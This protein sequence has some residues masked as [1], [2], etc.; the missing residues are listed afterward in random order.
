MAQVGLFFGSNTGNTEAVAYQ[1]QEAFNAIAPESV[2]V[3]NI[4][5]S[6]PEDI[7]KYDYLIFG[8]PTWNVGQLQD[9]WEAFLPKF[10]EM[11]MNGK[12]LAIFGLGDQNGYGFNF[13]DAVGML[14]DEA[15][16]AGAEL[17]GMWSTKD[18]YEYEESRAEVEDY[19]LGLPLDH[20]A[21]EDMCP[22]RIKQWV[23]EVKDEFGI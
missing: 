6:S 18:K 7:L 12:K 13:I 21:Q 22:A 23:Q 11:D 20:E 5:A 2:V 1:I 15:M 10:K 4:G 3:H 16:L 17:Y 9:D 19:F 14:A 8:V